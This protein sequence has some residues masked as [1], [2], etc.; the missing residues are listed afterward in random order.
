MT[1][2]PQE[3]LLRLS[4]ALSARELPTDLRDWLRQ[5]VKGFYAG[6]TLDDALG[7]NCR[8]GQRRASTA[9]RDFWLMMA[10]RYVSLETISPWE[11]A[12]RLSKAV[13]R[14]ETRVWPRA[15]RERSVSVQYADDPLGHCIEQ[16]FRANPNNGFPRSQRQLYRLLT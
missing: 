1:S 2:D 16:A 3:M 15:K 6:Q 5:G 9:S 13:K 4:V 14:F 11:C 8:P 10:S 7:L 12:G